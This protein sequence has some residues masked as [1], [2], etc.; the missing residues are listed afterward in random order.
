MLIPVHRI[1]GRSCKRRGR[2]KAN[3]VAHALVD[4][5]L[6]RLDSF[7]WLLHTGYA[8][9]H[10]KGRPVFMHHDVI[11]RAPGLEVSHKNADKL[12]N[13]RE[14]LEHVTRSDN[15]L[16]PA[17]GALG[18]NRSCGLRGVTRDDRSRSLARP[19]RGK[20]TVRGKTHQ[21]PRFAT[22]GE[23]ANALA[24]LGVDLRVREFPRQ[25]EKP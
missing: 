23:A 7:F 1:P 19:W 25:E 5:D 18:S 2:Q 17:D 11:G 9:R 15:M 14:N 10:A 8:A 6:G 3:V 12:D 4:N 22:A 20:V 13:R 16:N 21:T 24:Q